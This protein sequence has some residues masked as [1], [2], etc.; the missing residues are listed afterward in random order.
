MQTQG[1][2]LSW[3]IVKDIKE[4]IKFY[5]EV[6]G[7]KLKEF[8]EEYHWAELSGPDGCILGIGEEDSETNIKPGSNAV[9]TIKVKDIN[10]AIAHYKQKGAT[11]I[12][13]LIEIPGHVKMQ[14][15]A[16]KDG[17]M[18]QIVE[19]AEIEPGIAP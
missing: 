18:M 8:H 6:C 17:N 3:I 13:S 5:T 1:I 4:S 10:E 14:T 12:G 15:F 2:F 11:L 9:V 19:T 16:D 7:L